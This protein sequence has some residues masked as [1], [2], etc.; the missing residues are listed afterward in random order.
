MKQKNKPKKSQLDRLSI[1]RR[2]IRNLLRAYSGAIALDQFNVDA[3]PKNSFHVYYKREVWVHWR[4]R[5]IDFINKLLATTEALPSKLLS[6]LTVLAA[7]RDPVV[8]RETM[9]G[10][11]ATGAVGSIVPG[12]IDTATLF[13]QALL[14]SVGNEAFTPDDHRDCEHRKTRMTQW[15]ALIDPLSIAD[16][17]D[18]GYLEGLQPA[19]EK[20]AEDAK[21]PDH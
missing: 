11:L 8:V 9:V 10:M 16:D 7:R 2:D 19:S 6:S 1:T 13:F 21:L 12:Q 14:E 4:R 20:S 5:N 18:N 3:L 15:V 17:P